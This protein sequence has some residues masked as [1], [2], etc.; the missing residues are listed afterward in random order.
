MSDIKGTIKNIT[1]YI[2]YNNGETKTGVLCD[3][4]LKSLGAILLNPAICTKVLNSGLAGKAETLFKKA[5]KNS[6][7]SM[8]HPTVVMIG[9]D[10]TTLAAACYPSG[11]P[12]TIL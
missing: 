9:N 1:M 5:E 7:G 11:H 12:P 2:E 10:G 4:N 3:E 6:Q 8:E